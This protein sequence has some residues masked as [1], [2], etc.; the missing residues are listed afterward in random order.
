MLLFLIEFNFALMTTKPNLVA[1]KTRVH[2]ARIYFFIYKITHWRVCII[3]IMF[4]VW[5]ICSKSKNF[6]KW[7]LHKQRLEF[8]YWPTTETYRISTTF[9]QTSVKKHTSSTADST[10]NAMRK[11]HFFTLVA[12]LYHILSLSFIRPIISTCLVGLSVLCRPL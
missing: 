5:Q 4:I 2:K 3:N 9:C 10:P 11:F 6:T 12:L 7:K 8:G 1:A